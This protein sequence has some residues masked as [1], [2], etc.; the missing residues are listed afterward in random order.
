MRT[1]VIVYVMEKNFPFDKEPELAQEIRR[2]HQADAVEIVSCG[3]KHF[4]VMDAW[5][6][7]T[8]RGMQRFICVFAGYAKP[9]PSQPRRH[10][11][12]CE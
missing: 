12:L 1:G 8:A 3:Q 7:L 10:L 9:K 2:Y 5:W 4:D 6:K 11:R